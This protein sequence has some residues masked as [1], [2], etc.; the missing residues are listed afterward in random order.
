MPLALAASKEQPPQLSVKSDVSRLKAAAT[1][2][3]A[4]KVFEDLPLAELPSSPELASTRTTQEELESL[5]VSKP[6]KSEPSKTNPTKNDSSELTL[7]PIIRPSLASVAPVSYRSS[8]TIDKPSSA[9]IRSE[10]SDFT[11]NGGKFEEV[12]ESA[13]PPTP[14]S[15]LSSS[16]GT[17]TIDAE[18]ADS[19]PEINLF[20][21]DGNVKIS[22]NRFTMKADKVVANMRSAEQGQSGME[23][24]VGTGN[25]SVNMVTEG[26]APGYI[27][28]GGRAVYDPIAETIHLSGWPKIEEG[29]KALMANSATTVIVIDT[30]TAK[31]TTNGSTKT[32][33]RQP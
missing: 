13:K 6:T 17:M 10:P 21:F 18:R 7:P 15:P 29:N 3:P 23:K 31:I 32:V 5:P 1:A 25:V 27:A 8:P 24:V 20:T 14:K 22:C 16:L 12:P 19:K 33:L 2:P 28:S 11:P 4:A 26:D 30:K 9:L